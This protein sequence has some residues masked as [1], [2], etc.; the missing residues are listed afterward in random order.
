MLEKAHGVV[1]ISGS[2]KITGQKYGNR[3]LLYVPLEAGHVAQNMR[4][5]RRSLT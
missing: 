3:S 4:S 1:V 5:G 2:F